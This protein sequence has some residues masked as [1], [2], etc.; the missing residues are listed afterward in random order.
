MG[1]YTEA[2]F[3]S[4]LSRWKLLLPLRWYTADGVYKQ[5]L[6]DGLVAN[7]HPRSQAFRRPGP[8]LLFYRFYSL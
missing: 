4:V 1:L 5:N 2:T 8:T 7:S 6:K 3:L